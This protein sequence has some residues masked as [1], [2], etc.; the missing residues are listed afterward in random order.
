MGSNKTLIFGHRGAAGT[1][2]ENTMVSFQAALGSGAEGIELDVQLTKDGVPVVVHDE[3]LNRTTDGHGWVKD[4]ALAEIKTL[5]A[6]SWFSEG[7]SGERIPTL[8]ETVHWAK[9][10]NLLLNI[11]FKTAYIPYKGIEKAV[12]DCIKAFDMENRVILSSFN[13]YS[14][15]RAHEYA[16]NI[17]TA[18][19]FM[20]KLVS[21]GSYAS[22]INAR[23]LHPY[24]PI[25]DE[26]LLD[27]TNK[28]KMAVRPFTVNE[29]AAIKQLIEKGCSAIITDFPAKAVQ[30]RENI[31]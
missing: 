13:H 14:L 1:A 27:E 20:E 26:V 24:W 19:L 5:D 17:E 9:A 10:T 7:F 31:E 30:I 28:L 21:P 18:V 6:G 29:E 22:K 3:K 11:E 12:I 25:V 4:F 16:P 8:K 15:I 2:P 23:S